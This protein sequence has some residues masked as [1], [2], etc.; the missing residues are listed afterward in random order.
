MEQSMSDQFKQGQVLRACSSFG[1]AAG[2]TSDITPR[3][4][5][6][7]RA[8]LMSVSLRAVRVRAYGQSPSRDLRRKT[9]RLS[10]RQD[11]DC[12]TAGC[13]YPALISL[14]FVLERWLPFVAVFRDKSAQIWHYLL[15][16]I[17]LSKAIYCFVRDR[18]EIPFRT[19]GKRVHLWRSTAVSC[20]TVFC[21]FPSSI[22]G[23]G[24]L[25]QSALGILNNSIG[26]PYLNEYFNK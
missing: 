1:Q 20:T 9:D 24:V 4:F 8:L 17:H 6:A 19:S 14:L 2:D 21:I 13:G 5:Q 23:A 15:G 16:G 3:S 10:E 22:C 11:L 25:P 26:S 18:S 7:K 12:K